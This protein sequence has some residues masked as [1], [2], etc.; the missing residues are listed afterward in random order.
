MQDPH[1]QEMRTPYTDP[2][3]QKFNMGCPRSDEASVHQEL[4]L[5]LDVAADL[6][7]ETHVGP[8]QVP[9]LCSRRVAGCQKSLDSDAHHAP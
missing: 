8:I 4:F 1:F 3:L 5:E 6:I 9:E 2:F 7:V